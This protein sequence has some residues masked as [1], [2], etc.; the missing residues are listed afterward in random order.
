EEARDDSLTTDEEPEPDRRRERL[1]AAHLHRVVEERVRLVAGVVAGGELDHRRRQ[2]ARSV[3]LAPALQH[4]DEAREVRE[5]RQVAAGR[6]ISAMTACGT[7]I[8]YVTRAPGSDSGAVVHAQ[9]TRR[10]ML[11]SSSGASTGTRDAIPL[12]CVRRCTSRM[13]PLPRLPNSG[14]SSATGI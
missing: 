3:E 6:T 11:A 7:A 9:A 10:S 2:D 12:V 8:E 1:P 4:L 13:R 14:I 5:R